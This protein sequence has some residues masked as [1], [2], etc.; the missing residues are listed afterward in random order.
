M[1]NNFIIRNSIST[2]KAQGVIIRE[3]RAMREGETGN[4]IDQDVSVK[5]DGSEISC[6]G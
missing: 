1:E 2:R 5:V 4:V 6:N 3:A